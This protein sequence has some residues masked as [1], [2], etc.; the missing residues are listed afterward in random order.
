MNI[1]FEKI[2]QKGYDE[3][4]PKN[5]LLEP[6]AKTVIVVP[7]IAVTA[8]GK[9]NVVLQTGI[10]DGATESKTELA[11]KAVVTETVTSNGNVTMFPISSIDGKIT[12]W[13]SQAFVLDL[14]KEGKLKNE[15]FTERNELQTKSTKEATIAG[16]TDVKRLQFQIELERPEGRALI[17]GALHTS[18]A[19][20]K[21]TA[22]GKAK[23]VVLEA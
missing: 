8:N 22:K 19:T 15:H 16:A 2:G 4:L 18:V 12:R 6:F 20:T 11:N 14:V 21:P 10:K 5:D 1:T 7:C 3:K 23:K 17:V 9:T 13:V